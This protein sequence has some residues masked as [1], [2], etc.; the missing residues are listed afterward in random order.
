MVT[1][2]K[3]RLR[4]YRSV[5]VRPALDDWVELPNQGLLRGGL[6][7]THNLTECRDMLFYRWFTGS[8]DRLEAKDGSPG[9]PGTVGLAHPMLPYIESQKIKA[10][11]SFQGMGNTGFA[12]LQFQSDA[13][14]PAFDHLPGS[15]D[16]LPG[17]VK[18]HKVVGVANE[19][20]LALSYRE[21]LLDGLFDPVQSYIG[22]QWT[23]HS[24]LRCP[25]FRWG[26]VSTPSMTPALSHPLTVCL[27]VG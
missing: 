13:L 15:F 6:M 3:R 18:H 19:A 25:L 23:Q 16:T 21:G 20:G 7:L 11:I 9:V 8:D 22:E 10:R 1:Q 12:W 26:R 5:I 2:V 4:D 24:P 17:R 14:Q 27:M